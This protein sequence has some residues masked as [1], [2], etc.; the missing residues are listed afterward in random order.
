MNTKIL[1]NIALKDFAGGIE[2]QT[3]FLR[4]LA[5]QKMSEFFKPSHAI[6]RPQ[7]SVLL[8]VKWLI[9]V[10]ALTVNILIAE[11]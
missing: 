5:V 11:F 8:L 10:C 3:N 1:L 2:Y 7:V 9:I 6:L 4:C